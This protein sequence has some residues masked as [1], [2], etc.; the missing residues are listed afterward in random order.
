MR[1]LKNYIIHLLGGVTDEEQ[2]KSNGN[3]VEIG[4]YIAFTLMQ[5]K[6]QSQHGMAADE[7]AKGAYEYVENK[8][9]ELTKVEEQ[10]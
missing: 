2:R 6:M 10:S 5:R 4:K 9:Q 8:L 7:W 1:R 3:C